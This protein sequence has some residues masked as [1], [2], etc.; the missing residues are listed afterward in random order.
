[1]DAA[2]IKVTIRP[3]QE[4]KALRVMELNEDSAEIRIIYFYDTHKLDFYRAGVALRSRLVK[5]DADDS[6]VKFRP[7]QD[8]TVSKDWKKMDGFKLEADCVGDL[9]V[10][11]ASLS[12]V[13]N[14]DDIDRVAKGKRAIRRLFTKDQEKFLSEF[15]KRPFHF[16]SLKVLGPIRVLRWKLKHKGFPYEITTEEWRLPDD[17]VLV[18]VSIK[19]APGQAR[20]ARKAFDRHLRQLGLDPAGAQQTKTRTAL[21]YFVKNYRKKARVKI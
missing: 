19:V 1:M 11:S 18:E 15:H 17:E 5:G 7:V 2:E 4:L 13:Q 6:T 20:R 8:G 14:R 12:A 21:E 3:D 16:K 10:C 9:V